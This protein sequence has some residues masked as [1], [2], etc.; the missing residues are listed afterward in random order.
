MSNGE[1]QVSTEHPAGGAIVRPNAWIKTLRF[2]DGTQLE[3]GRHEILVLVGPNN[4][5]KSVALRD[6]L[7]KLETRS[8]QTSVVKQ[9]AIDTGGD[10]ASFVRW[11]ESFPRRVSIANN[12]NTYDLP[13][14]RL[15]SAH[16]SQWGEAR[17]HGLYALT[18]IFAIHLSTEAR[19]QA[20]NPVQSINF[21]V[22]PPTSPLQ[23]LYESDEHEE[24]L[25]RIFREAF[26]HDLI[27][28]RVAGSMIVL[29]VG[30]RPVPRGGDR[31][32]S[33]YRHA[34][35]MLPTLDSQGDGI[36]A[37]VG[38][39]LHALVVDRDIIL[40]DEPDAFLHPP[41][42][43]FL[44]RVLAVETPSPRQLIVATHSTDFLRGI[45]D[46]PASSVRVVRIRRKGD[47][48]HV[49]ELVPEAVREVWRDPLLR[50][51]N[52]LDGLFHDGVI[53]CEG[54][55]DC[56]FYGAMMDAVARRRQ[57]PSSHDNQ[58]APS[59]RRA[60]PR[61]VGFRRIKRRNRTPI[62]LRESG[63]KLG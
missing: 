25:S 34:I 8:V 3:L 33:S 39:L 60:C 42:A 28:N 58:S 47:A 51:S 41:Q 17:N 35:N 36:R 44:G 10:L 54:D 62:Y 29:H 46:A 15:T 49:R 9:V 20:A 38:V 24:R 32:A 6:I 13:I 50:Y 2:S 26:N 19:L 27:V 55:G 11:V 37:F 16:I 22:E 52:V 45:L 4:A 63:R 23:H 59:N 61:G 14:G 1:D 7:S 31:Q 53:I 18:P 5:G 12:P 56:R 21:V 30:T 57:E 40:I 48:N 43:A